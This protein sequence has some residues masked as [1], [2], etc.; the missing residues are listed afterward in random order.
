[1]LLNAWTTTSL[2]HRGHIPIQLLQ[3]SG[4]HSR[5]SRAAQTPMGKRKLVRAVVVV[6]ML[7]VRI[8]RRTADV[9]RAAERELEV[10]SNPALAVATPVQRPLP[11][12]AQGRLHHV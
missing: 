9:Q 6:C 3:G 10:L 8:H 5:C 1:M 4:R 11:P 2:K 7:S 12:Q